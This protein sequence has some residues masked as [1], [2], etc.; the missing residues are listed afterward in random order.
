MVATNVDILV[1]NVA[2]Q[3]VFAHIIANRIGRGVEGAGWLI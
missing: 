2:L 3:S 1:E